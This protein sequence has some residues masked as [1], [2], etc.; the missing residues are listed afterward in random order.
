MAVLTYIDFFSTSIQVSHLPFW[1][2]ILLIEFVILFPP[3]PKDQKFEILICK[4]GLDQR[5]A[6]R[7]VVN[8]CQKLPSKCPPTLID[9]VPILCNLLQCEDGQVWIT[10][11]EYFILLYF[12]F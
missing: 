9:A 5:I 10:E 8:V 11:L 1:M 6:L 2:L 4:S 7:T 12:N 3:N